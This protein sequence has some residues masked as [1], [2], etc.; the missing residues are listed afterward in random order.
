MKMTV[1]LAMPRPA[2]PARATN[3]WATTAD[4][5]IVSN[6]STIVTGLR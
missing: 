4:M 1:W 2:D 3:R 6:G 5:P